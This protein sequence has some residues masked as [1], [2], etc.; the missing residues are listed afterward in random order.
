MADWHEISGE[1][2]KCFCPS[3]AEGF[4]VDWDTVA[5]YV[6]MYIC[7]YTCLVYGE[8]HV[9]WNVRPVFIF[10]SGCS[11]V[12]KLSPQAPVKPETSVKGL[13]SCGCTYDDCWNS[14]APH[15][16]WDFIR[17][18]AF[19]LASGRDQEIRVSGL[20]MFEHVIQRQ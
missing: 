5:H 16:S 14:C 12:R 19:L 8:T 4:S 18:G 7:V 10:L 9:P 15:C 2:R 11:R 17:Q 6:Y 13:V 1:K 20:K 3:Q